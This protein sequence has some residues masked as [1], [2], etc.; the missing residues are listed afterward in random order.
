MKLDRPTHGSGCQIEQVADEVIGVLS[1][2]A[3]DLEL[4]P[5]KMLEVGG[6]DH[7]GPDTNGRGEYVSIVPVGEFQAGY[8]A[9]IAFHQ[10]IGDHRVHQFSRSLQP[11]AVEVGAAMQQA[12][13]SLVVDCI[14][15]TR[16]E[17]IGGGQVH[18]QITQG[19]GVQNGGIV[20]GREGRHAQ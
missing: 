17:Q 7:I 12:V 5:R 16:P 10:A 15:P 9:F 18:Q 2:Q 11:L 6:Y 3:V 19:S 20:D 1:L 14:G 8:Q 13:D 4:L